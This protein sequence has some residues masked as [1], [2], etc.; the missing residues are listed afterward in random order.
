MK[1]TGNF[2]ACQDVDPM[3]ALRT[4]ETV[5]DA[6][7]GVHRPDGTLRWLKINAQILDPDATGGDTDAEP[8]GSAGS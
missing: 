7:M 5:R 1:P 4:G 8:A 2:A 6:I 3:V